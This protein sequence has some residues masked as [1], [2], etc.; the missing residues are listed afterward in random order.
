VKPAIQWLMWSPRRFYSVTGC[1][2][3]VVVLACTVSIGG[4]VSRVG[5]AATRSTGTTA[6]TTPWPSPAATTPSPPPTSTLPGQAGAVAA[7]LLL[8]PTQPTGTA[9]VES[10]DESEVVI[11]VPVR[12]GLLD[13]LVEHDTNG[14]TA[15]S[16]AKAR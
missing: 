2:I 9:F 12:N 14:W 15:T 8:V 16:Y 6:P 13:V 10:G 1:L 4:G 5:D 11:R 3:A 7:A